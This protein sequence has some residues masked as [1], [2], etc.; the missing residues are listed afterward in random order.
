MVEHLLTLCESLGSTFSTKKGTLG[1]DQLN[2]ECSTFLRE[3]SSN[4]KESP[5]S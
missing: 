5:L 4:V 2:F 3:H 1:L